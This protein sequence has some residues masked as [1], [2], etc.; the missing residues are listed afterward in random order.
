LLF[1]LQTKHIIRLKHEE[2][3]SRQKIT[4]SSIP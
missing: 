3:L 2:K 1:S 4:S